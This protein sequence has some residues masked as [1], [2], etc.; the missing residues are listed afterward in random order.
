M[1]FW[2]S[3]LP[4]KWIKIT[5]CNNRNS[6][7]PK[8]TEFYPQNLNWHIIENL[9]DWIY[10]SNMLRLCSGYMRN[11]QWCNSKYQEACPFV[12]YNATNSRSTRR[13]IQVFDA[14]FD[15]LVFVTD[16]PDETLGRQSCVWFRCLLK[17]LPGRSSSGLSRLLILMYHL[18][19][20]LSCIIIQ[21]KS[22][23]N[24]VVLYKI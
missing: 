13:G 2:Y 12:I 6:N 11:V 14:V 22:T 5:N 18:R 20:F 4:A 19:M 23:Q 1:L 15:N 10:N 8:L 3:F 24:A 7:L 21:N 16:Y 17:A 9:S